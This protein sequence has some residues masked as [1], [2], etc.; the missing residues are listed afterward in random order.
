MMNKMITIKIVPRKDIIPYIVNIK[1][2]Y[3]VVISINTE[4]NIEIL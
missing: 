3:Y 1:N 4:M 2:S